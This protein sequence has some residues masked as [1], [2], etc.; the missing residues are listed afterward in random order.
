MNHT[1]RNGEDP[2]KTITYQLLY[3]YLGGR[4]F[5]VMLIAGLTGLYSMIT[6]YQ[7]SFEGL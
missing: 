5:N 3:L 1:G 6:A 7:Y 4:V 2:W